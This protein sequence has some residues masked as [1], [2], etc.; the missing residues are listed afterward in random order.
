M[1]KL[2]FSICLL[3]G[4][5]CFATQD[6]KECDKKPNKAKILE[7]YARKAHDNIMNS[8]DDTYK[9]QELDIFKSVSKICYDDTKKEILKSLDSNN[10]DDKNNRIF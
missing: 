2:L 1:K 5:L 3:S 4:S 6:Y 8:K 10:I 7:C 9:Q